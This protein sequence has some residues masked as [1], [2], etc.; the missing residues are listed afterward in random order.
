MTSQ[1]R[2]VLAALV[3][4][5]LLA[6]AAVPTAAGTEDQEPLVFQLT[7]SGNVHPDD[8][9]GLERLCVEKD[10]ACAFIDSHGIFCV[11]EPLATAEHPA[12]E[13]G[14]FT[15][16]YEREAGVTVEYSLVRWTSPPIAGADLERHLSDSV[17][18]PDG[19]ITVSL[20]YDYSL[21]ADTPALPDT[22][23]RTAVPIVPLGIALVAT[24]LVL[25]RP[26]PA[27]KRSGGRRRE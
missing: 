15:L 19:G 3:T 25:G 23:S 1:I 2:A 24:A 22:A 16:D 6:V 27:R 13:T 5:L 14:T 21:S 26:E 9:F 12:C 17:T 7:L 20:G 10:P 8:S 4:L 18:V 11:A